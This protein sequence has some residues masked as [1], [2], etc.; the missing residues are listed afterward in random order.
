[1]FDAKLQQPNSSA[2]V[3]CCMASFG[4][5][6]TLCHYDSLYAMTL[7]MCEESLPPSAF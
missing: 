2:P 4:I 6:T 7:C 3:M 1:M 5:S